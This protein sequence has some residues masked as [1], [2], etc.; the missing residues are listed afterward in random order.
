MMLAGWLL[1]PASVEMPQKIQDQKQAKPKYP[2]QGSK[3]FK[4]RVQFSR[5]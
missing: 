1:L 3:F 2:F 5:G 4:S